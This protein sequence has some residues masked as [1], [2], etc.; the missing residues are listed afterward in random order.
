MHPFHV[1]NN[2]TYWM[3]SRASQMEYIFIVF[4]NI[5]AIPFPSF[6]SEYSNGN[7]DKNND[8]KKTTRT[9]IIYQSIFHVKS[10]TSLR[11]FP[12][13]LWPM[14]YVCIPTPFV[15]S[16]VRQT[17]FYSLFVYFLLL[18]HSPSLHPCFFSTF[19]TCC[20]IIN[21]NDKPIAHSVAWEACD[22]QD[23]NIR[24]F[25]NQNGNTSRRI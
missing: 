10:L 17:W 8:N 2:A 3:R 18:I 1:I 15:Y 13:S 23:T 9:N 7:N 14:P 4:K 16:C 24:K 25:L 19:S 22:L 5:F 12:L 6:L 21:S 11:H 20:Y